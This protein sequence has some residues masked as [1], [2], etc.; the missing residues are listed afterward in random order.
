MEPVWPPMMPSCRPRRRCQAKTMPE[1][2]A[3]HL[4]HEFRVAG[5]MQAQGEG[6]AQDPLPV[7]SR[8]KQVVDKAG[9]NIG[10]AACL[11]TG[12]EPAFA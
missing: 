7:G 6:E 5:E 4:R 8:R 9:R 2:G 3:E 1:E 12:A 11:T 10:C